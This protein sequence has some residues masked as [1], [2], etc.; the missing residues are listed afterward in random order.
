MIAP[1]LGRFEGK[2]L[3]EFVGESGCTCLICGAD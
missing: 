3:A 1:W 2:A